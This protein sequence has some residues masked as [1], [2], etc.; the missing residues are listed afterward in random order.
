LRSDRGG[1]SATEWI[2]SG[3]SRAPSTTISAPL[4][5]VAAQH[6]D[7]AAKERVSYSW[8]INPAGKTRLPHVW[9]CSRPPGWRLGLSTSP[10]RPVVARALSTNTAHVQAIFG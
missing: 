4:L 1:L 9:S 10:D 2:P 8:V 6:Y 7:H 3:Q 5:M